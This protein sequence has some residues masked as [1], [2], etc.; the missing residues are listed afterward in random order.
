MR[1]THQARLPAN[2][3]ARAIVKGSVLAA[4]LVCGSAANAALS[5]TF[6]YST[7]TAG[8]GFDDAVTGAAR[9]AALDTAGVRFSAMFGSFFDHT[10]N[11]VLQA[12]STDDVLG[13]GGGTLASAGSQLTF[14]P[15]FGGTEVVRNKVISNGATDLNGA[16]TD[17]SVDINWGA[18]WELDP[19][20]PAVAGPFAPGAGTF[21]LYAALFHEFSHALGFASLIGQD[22]K[23][24]FGRGTTVAS[25][26]TGEPGNWSKFDQFLTNCS[27]ASLI[28]AGTGLTNLAV[29]TPAITSSVCFE[30]AEVGS[31]KMY[32]PASYAPGSSVSHLDGSGTNVLA[33]MKFD[34][35]TGPQEA[36]VYNADEV[37]IL[38]S[39]GYRLAVTAVPEPGSIALVLA[40]LGGAAWVRRRK[41]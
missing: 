27:G 39:I 19:D 13:P 1:S 3:T 4:C 2:R 8:V 17:G 7:N 38:T 37:N 32:T 21:D 11:I 15:G 36:R 16:S 33:M 26:G 30:S 10:A 28:D 34:R 20:T 9:K 29:Y 23:D 5:F 22:G 40:A 31:V 25:G 14:A 18:G 41:A 35:D 12:T 6:D 24:P